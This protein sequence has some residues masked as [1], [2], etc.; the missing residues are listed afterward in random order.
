MPDVA[1][2]IDPQTFVG[3]L[4]LAG[5]DLLQGDELATVL[6]VSLFT[7]RG[8]WWADA[9]EPD[10]TGSRLLTLRRAKRTQATLNK[11][12]DY[13]REALAWMIEDGVAQTVNVITEWQGERLAIGITVFQPRGRVT[14]YDFAWA[15]V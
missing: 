1:I 10:P 6:Y 8:S 14:R 9:Y 11:A 15:G 2:T 5:G 12:A 7:L 13:V 3:D 4:Q